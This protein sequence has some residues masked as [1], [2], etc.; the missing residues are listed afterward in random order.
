ADPSDRQLGN[1]LLALLHE[2]HVD[3]TSFFRA[4]SNLET[5]PAFGEWSSRWTQRLL[6][7]GRDQR[8]VAAAM[9]AVNPIYVPRNHLVEEALAAA[10]GN[11]DL[12]PLHRLLEAVTEPFD[13]RAGFERYATPDLAAAADYQT[14]CGT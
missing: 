2:K 9:D 1:Y 3:F 10:S 8:E 7:E 6:D 11:G 5:P 14:F 4:L 13:Q 12:E